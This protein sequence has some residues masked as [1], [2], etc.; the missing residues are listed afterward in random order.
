MPVRFLTP[1]QRENYG[2]Y[3][4]SPTPDELSRFFHLNDDDLAQI[5]SCRGEHNRLGF[6]LQTL[7]RALSR[8]LSRRS[9]GGAFPGRADARAP[10]E[11]LQPRVSASLSGWQ[12]TLGAC[13]PDT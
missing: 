4:A 3:A 5:R 10:T 12:A 2:R 9:C 8:D 6:A 13:R 1:E 7:H 11:H